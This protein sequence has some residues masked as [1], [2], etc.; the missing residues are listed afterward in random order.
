MLDAGVAIA[1][2]L[3]GSPVSDFSNLGYVD[4]EIL[5]RTDDR[6]VCQHAYSFSLNLG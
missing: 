4:H 1:L 3:D 5:S 2:R 6:M